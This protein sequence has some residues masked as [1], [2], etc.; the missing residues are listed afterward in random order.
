MIRRPPRSTLFPYTPLFR[1]DGLWGAF[2]YGRYS[3]VGF[4]ERPEPN[5]AALN[6]HA[7]ASTRGSWSLVA[8]AEAPAW[9]EGWRAGLTLTA[10]RDN[11]L[12]FYGL[13]NDTRYFADSAAGGS[14][15]YQVSRTRAAARLTIQRRIVGPVRLLAGAAVVRTDFRAL[16]GDNIFRRDLAS[17]AV[18]PATVPFTD[19]VARGGIVLDARDH[20]IDPHRGVFLEALFA[21]GTGYTR[22]TAHARVLVHPLERLVLAARLAGEGTG[23]RPPLAAPLAVESR[24]PPFTPVGG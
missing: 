9:W 7:S 16:P 20:E 11:R 8:D 3:P 2:H 1:S 4:V 21:S 22:T 18:D 12:G 17:G 13:G 19:R 23:G 5:L 10:A 15:F 24:G 6:F 14:H